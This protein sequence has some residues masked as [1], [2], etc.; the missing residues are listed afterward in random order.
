MTGAYYPIEGGYLARQVELKRFV[1]SDKHKLE[2]Q[3]AGYRF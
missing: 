2:D 3:D 1:D